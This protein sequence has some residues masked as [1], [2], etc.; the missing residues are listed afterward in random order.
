MLQGYGRGP[1]IHVFPQG[2]PAPWQLGG[3]MCLVLA[4]EMCVKIIYIRVPIMVQGKQIWLG[5]M[6]L[7]VQSLASLNGLRIWHCCELWCGLQTWLGSGIVVA[8][9]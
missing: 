9:V 3:T 6:R 2:V 4:H 8:V 1:K 5:T 7:Q